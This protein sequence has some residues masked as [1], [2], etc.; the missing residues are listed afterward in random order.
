MYYDILG[1]IFGISDVAGQRVQVTKATIE[2]VK[3]TLGE[4]V[5]K[6]LVSVF[7]YDS[8][9]DAPFTAC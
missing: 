6:D 5:Y 3:N 7:V 9:E 2:E 4:D 8:G 1:H